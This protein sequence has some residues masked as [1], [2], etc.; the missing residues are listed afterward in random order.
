MKQEN[1]IQ[2]LAGVNKIARQSTKAIKESSA[3]YL[4]QEIIKGKYVT[5]QEYE[6][7][8]KLVIKLEKEI[9]ELK[10]N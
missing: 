7:L 5:R 6:Q 4:E 2:I 1:I 9:K 3:D 10:S 8:Q